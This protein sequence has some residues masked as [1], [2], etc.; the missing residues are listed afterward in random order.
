MGNMFNA[1]TQQIRQQPVCHPPPP[2]PPPP[3]PCLRASCMIPTPCVPTEQQSVVMH[4]W[5]ICP[6]LQR[7]IVTVGIGPGT[8]NLPSPIPED[9]EDLNGFWTAP[10][11]PGFYSGVIRFI[12]P[13][14]ALV[15]APWAVQ[16][17]AP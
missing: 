9:Q 11:L 7:D 14:G 16:V 3:D 4:P 12:W 5:S 2:P 17:N 13:G 8:W 10:S 15:D 6:H 1:K